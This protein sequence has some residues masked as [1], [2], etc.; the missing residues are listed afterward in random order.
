MATMIIDRAVL[1]EPVSSCFAAPRLA[2]VQQRGRDVLLSPN[3][4]PPFQN[5]EK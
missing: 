2:V 4:I 3:T 1:P 5:Q